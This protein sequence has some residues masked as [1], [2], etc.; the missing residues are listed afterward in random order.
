MLIN[1]LGAGIETVNSMGETPLI[2]ASKRGRHD[3]LTFLIEEGVNL[4][5]REHCGGT[6]LA[7]AAFW[8]KEEVVRILLSAGACISVDNKGMT[9]LDYAVEKYNMSGS[10]KHKRIVNMLKGESV[11]PSLETD[12][13]NSKLSE[14]T[15]AA[16]RGSLAQY[17]D[18]QDVSLS[19]I[20][21]FIVSQTVVVSLKNLLQT[22]WFGGDV[23]QRDNVSR[24]PLHFAAYFGT[25]ATV[26]AL[27]E[28]GAPVNSQTMNGVTPLHNAA[29][30]E[31]P[32]IV[33]VLLQARASISTKTKRGQL[34]IHMAARFA[35]LESLRMLLVAKSDV[36][37]KTNDEYDPLFYAALRRDATIVAQLVKSR[38]SVHETYANKDIFQV[39]SCNTVDRE[40][41]LSVLR[42]HRRV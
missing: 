42:E 9:A 11:I 32:G 37:A 7:L 25:E 16:L 19:L 40:N 14:L 36:K 1:E 41:V 22:L 39:A 30:R 35:D 4:E 8:G 28:A 21:Q 12:N 6:A 18:T 27:L 17:L 31:I 2:L 10:N 34:P 20:S 33:R 15:K 26:T 24:T 23:E 13:E 38:A 5:H 29:Y 3:V